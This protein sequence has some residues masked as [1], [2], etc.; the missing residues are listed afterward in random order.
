[1]Q[2][3]YQC[4]RCGTGWLAT[5]VEHSGQGWAVHV[6]VCSHCRYAS[7]PGVP[8]AVQGGEGALPLSVRL[9][10]VPVARL[11]GP[12]VETLRMAEI[13]T[14]LGLRPAAPGSE[15]RRPVRALPAAGLAS[16]SGER[17]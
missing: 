5:M 15:A 7:Q 12:E 13:F 4:T 17:T 6:F 3:I 1:M 8:L 9:A 2:H 10:M 16:S 11:A 14:L